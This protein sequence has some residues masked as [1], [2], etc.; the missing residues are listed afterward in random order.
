[1]LDDVRGLANPALKLLGYS[2]N[3]SHPEQ[4]EEAKRLL[5]S[6]KPLVKEYALS[7]HLNSYVW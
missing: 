7:C 6:Q 5:L 4:I 2:I 1:M 3:T